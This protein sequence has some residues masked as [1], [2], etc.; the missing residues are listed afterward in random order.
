MTI[1][2]FWF[3]K[4]GKYAPSHN[5]EGIAMGMRGCALFYHAVHILKWK[6]IYISFYV[7]VLYH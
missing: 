3:S 6:E 7:D 1:I 5:I 4:C 2:S